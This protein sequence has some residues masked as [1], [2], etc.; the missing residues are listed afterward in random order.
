MKKGELVFETLL[1]RGA[2][3]DM[4]VSEGRVWAVDNGTERLI[5]FSTAGKLLATRSIPGVSHFV[6]SSWDR[7]IVDHTGWVC[8]RAGEP[9][10]A[11]LEYPRVA[12]G[13]PTCPARAYPVETGSVGAILALPQGGVA[14]ALYKSNQ[15]LILGE[16]EAR[17]HAHRDSPDETGP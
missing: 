14:V 11:I 9:A 1:E 5:E 4:T 13:I 12:G 16:S 10:T 3:T 7:V 15:V 8:S 2:L 17:A 6:D